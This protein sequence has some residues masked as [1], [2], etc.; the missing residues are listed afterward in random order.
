M[1]KTLNDLRDSGHRA[2]TVIQITARTDHDIQAT[3]QGDST[4]QTFM[5]DPQS[6]RQCQLNDPDIFKD[7]SLVNGEWV[8]A[9]SGKR[10][11][12]Y[13]LSCS[14]EMVCSY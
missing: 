6:D 10:F 3:I 2:R 8:E 7:K 5:I 1:I 9:K 14:L 11:D 4:R 12:I 13:G